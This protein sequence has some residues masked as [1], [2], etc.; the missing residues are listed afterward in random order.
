MDVS[1]NAFSVSL[2]VDFSIVDSSVGFS[3]MVAPMNVYY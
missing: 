3:I 2:I 1:L